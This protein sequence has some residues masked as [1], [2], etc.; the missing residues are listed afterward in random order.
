VSSRFGR[1][2][3]VLALLCAIGLAAP[4]LA[5]VEIYRPQRRLAEEL[6][7]IAA[8]LLGTAGIAVADPG[9]GVVVLHGPREDLH[10]ALAALRRADVV[11]RTWNV[12]AVLTRL[13]EIER[14][15]LSVGG[16]IEVGQIRVGRIPAGESPGLTLRAR[17]LLAEGA[18]RFEGQTAVQDGSAA[19]IWT[20]AT[21]PE[22]SQ[23]LERST[24]PAG[25]QITRIRETTALIPVQTGFRVLPRG[26]ADGHIELE[27][28]P[29]LSA[30]AADGGV[31]RTAASS[32]LNVR[33]G[34][35]VAIAA[36]E[37]AGDDLVID[38]FGSVDHR[39][40]ARD[41]VLLVR[42]DPLEAGVSPPADSAR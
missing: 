10:A 13:S 31:V 29:L 40:E 35:L 33:R 27:I 15:Q 12:T 42:V 25:E 8:G 17:S 11:L 18:V 7:P 38:P 20:G 21:Y 30:R 32:H 16:W 14:V 6:A 22:R 37:G 36:A 2:A 34:E 39:E 24:G 3:R 9:S 5:D 26:R 1:L 28:A 19:E 4:A 41:S 23:T